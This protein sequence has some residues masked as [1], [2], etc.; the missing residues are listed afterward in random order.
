MWKFIYFIVSFGYK[1]YSCVV[2]QI[3]CMQ[4]LNIVLYMIV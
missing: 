2:Y 4:F 3:E 1:L